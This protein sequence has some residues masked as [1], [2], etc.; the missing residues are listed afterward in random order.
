[1]KN[2]IVL[3]FLLGVGFS[4]VYCSATDRARI[5]M[6]TQS[7]TEIEA[8]LLKAL[9]EA[10]APAL[11]MKEL[12]DTRSSDQNRIANAHSEGRA[13]LG[14]VQKCKFKYVYRFGNI[15]YIKFIKAH[16]Y[17]WGLGIFW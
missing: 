12:Q 8:E 7:R 3:L 15:E 1:M 17:G 5:Q 4:F 6:E 16:D 14:E 9:N 2:Y 13:Y 11:E 10:K